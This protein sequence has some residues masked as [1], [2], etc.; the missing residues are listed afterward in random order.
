MK[1]TNVIDKD[2]SIDYDLAQRMLTLATVRDR[3][4]V[5]YED[6]KGM[7][8]VKDTSLSNPVKQE[9][10]DSLAR[11]YLVATT[12]NAMKALEMED[13]PTEGELLETLIKL[14]SSGQYGQI[15]FPTVL[16]YLESRGI[17]PSSDSIWGFPQML[18]DGLLNGGVVMQGVSVQGNVDLVHAVLLYGLKIEEGEIFLCT[19]DPDPSRPEREWIT[20]RDHTEYLYGA[21]GLTNL[22]LLVRDI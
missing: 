17:N 4:K 16:R 5:V 19:Y 7:S 12:I 14:G 21:E 1:T 2:V 3:T 9:R 18:V 13:I 8:V 20:L 15:E 11:T 10:N 22:R 6:Y